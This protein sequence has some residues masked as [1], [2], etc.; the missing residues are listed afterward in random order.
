VLKQTALE[1]NYFKDTITQSNARREIRSITNKENGENTK[2]SD[3]QVISNEISTQTSFAA[4]HAEQDCQQAARITSRRTFLNM[5][6]SQ[7][8]KMQKQK[9]KQLIEVQKHEK[10]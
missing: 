8:D 1:S 5:N 3:H 4:I 7:F 9:F 6:S 2:K 10:R